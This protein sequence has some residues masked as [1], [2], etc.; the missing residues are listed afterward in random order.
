MG[1]FLFEGNAAE[2]TPAVC[3]GKQIVNK[4]VFI[5]K[6]QLIFDS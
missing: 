4:W 1:G 2:E 3:C 6:S 5:L